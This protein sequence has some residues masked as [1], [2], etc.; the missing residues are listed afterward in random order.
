MHII[1]FPLILIFFLFSQLGHAEETPESWYQIEY[2]LFEHLKSDR[3]V[4]RHEDVKYNLVDKEQYLYL[5]TK[6]TVVSPYQLKKIE[7][8]KSDF[9]DILDRISKSDELKVYST[10]SWQQAIQRGEKIPPL[11]ITG[12]Q[13]YDN[14]Q[15]FQLEGELQIKRERY[16][17]ASINVFLADFTT[18]PYNNLQ[19]WFFEADDKKW[20][21]DWLLQPL[22]FEHPTLNKTGQSFIANNVIHFKQSRRIKDA[23]VHYID[24]P[25]LGLMITIKEIAPPFEY[26]AGNDF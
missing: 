18:V 14:G 9:T 24:H 22:A 17:H 7:K 8:E 5:S 2:I 26:G 13:S 16:M 1:F 21:I 15:R 3:H 10:G 6:N 23:E 20:P 11:K 25:A 4:L 12:G 19:S